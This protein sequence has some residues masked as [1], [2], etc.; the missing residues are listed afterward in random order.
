[1]LELEEAQRRIL[2]VV[3]PLDVEKVSLEKAA[4][5]FLADKIISPINLPPFDNSAMDG[6]ALRAQDVAT[7][8]PTTPAGLR[9]LGTVAAGEI[10]SIEVPPGACVRIFTGSVLPAGADAVVMQEDTHADANDAKLIWIL[11]T[12]RTWENLRFAGEDLKPGAPVAQPGDCLTA[13]RLGLL[14]A[15]GFAEVPCF[16]QPTVGLL[17]TGNELVE[18]GS[19]LPAGK[20]Y[21]SNR[22]SLA[23]L[24]SRAGGVAKIFPLV[25]DTL[26]ATCVALE[27][28]LTEC[29][30]VVTAG[31]VSV[32][33]LDLVKS[34]FQKLGGEME[35]WKVAIKPG[36][37]FGFGRWRDK[38]WFGLPGNPVSAFVTFLLL[39]RPAVLRC[40]G[41]SNFSLPL[42]QGTLVESLANPGDRRH[43]VRVRVDDLARI[44]TAGV[45][46]SHILSS[47]AEANGLVDV[48]PRT[49]LTAGTSVNVLNWE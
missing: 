12:A 34:A 41:A 38:L 27:A 3:A 7:A 37:P 29:D 44:H 11:D 17:A 48:P 47:L 6:Y 40:Q 18:G 19:P 22:V 23:S 49:T 9:L 33:E 13:G 28:A 1:M 42:R 31:G 20:I 25:K 4:G 21:E 10:C 5:R 46:A 26:K 2:S 45:Q 39:V 24:V 36:K 8:G 15:I 16:R 30:L 32:G 14:A 43:F 35:F